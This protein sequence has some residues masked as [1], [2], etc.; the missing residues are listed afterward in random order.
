MQPKLLFGDKDL[1]R[2]F[3]ELNETWEVELPIEASLKWFLEGLMAEERAVYLAAGFRERTPKRRDWANGHYV[4]DLGTEGGLIRALRVAP[5]SRRRLSEPG[6]VALPA[7]PGGG[8]PHASRLL[9]GRG[10]H[11]PGGGVRE[12]VVG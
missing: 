5:G 12:G 3:Q 8:G 7:P 6:V 11:P 9:P 2:A 4:R 10:V 1:G